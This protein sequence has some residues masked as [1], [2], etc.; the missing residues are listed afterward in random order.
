MNNLNACLSIFDVDDTLFKTKANVLIKHSSGN[1]KSLP[2]G[3]FTKYQLEEDEE[4]DFR[5]F[6]DAELF[7]TTSEP[8][9]HVINK[10]KQLVL[11][12]GERLGSEVVII[13]AREPLD[14]ID[15][16]IKTFHDHGLHIHSDK[17][18]TVGSSSNKK[19]L[20]RKMLLDNK[21]SEVRLFD[22]HINNITDF[23]SLKQ[24]FPDITFYAYPIKNGDICEVI[25]V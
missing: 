4:Y 10:A 7:R 25:T 15:V 24:E 13:T 1:I 20:I 3:E 22:D 9:H 5:E 16:F 11:E 12:I 19:P 8:N 21:F 2:V 14:N 18:H 6:L 17:V 23:L